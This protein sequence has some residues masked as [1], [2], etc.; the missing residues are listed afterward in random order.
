MAPPEGKS[1]RLKTKVGGRRKH[2]HASRI[3]K[4]RQNG[5]SNNMRIKLLWLPAALTVFLC[6]VTIRQQSNYLGDLAQ[7]YSSSTWMMS[8]TAAAPK[9][10]SQSE[11]NKTAIEFGSVF[12][13]ED[14]QVHSCPEI[15]TAQYNTT[16]SD[17]AKQFKATPI[18]SWKFKVLL[19]LCW[20]ECRFLVVLDPI[21]I[22]SL[23]WIYYVTQRQCCNNSFI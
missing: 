12:K 17:N 23:R 14:D 18:Q 6:W 2:H 9:N 8:S 3:M 1:P 11:A 4:K 7:T 19:L 21:I 20:L 5:E 15:Q 22:T 10:E 13:I 16:I